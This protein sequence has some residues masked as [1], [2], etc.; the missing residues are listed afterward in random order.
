MQQ[1]DEWMTAEVLREQCAET[2]VRL[3]WARGLHLQFDVFYIDSA[4]QVWQVIVF[5]GTWRSW[6]GRA[7]FK[8]LLW[9]PECRFAV[10]TFHELIPLWLDWKVGAA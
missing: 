9:Q 3:V 2:Y 5:L 4:E 10:V 1:A 6:R 7:I 8:W